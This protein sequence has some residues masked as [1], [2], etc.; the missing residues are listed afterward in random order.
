MMGSK[1]V[2]AALNYQLTEHK[3]K[4]LETGTCK[5]NGFSTACTYC[6]TNKIRGVTITA[7]TKDTSSEMAMHMESLFSFV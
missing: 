6:P 5:K 2:R 4:D 7:W 3:L 1:E